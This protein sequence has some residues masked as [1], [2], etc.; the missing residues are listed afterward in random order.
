M[1]EMFL[2]YIWQ[3]QYFNRVDLATTAGEPLHVFSAGLRN[4]DSGP[5]FQNAK[6]RLGEMQWVG[7]VEIHVKASGWAQHR[8]DDDE[9]YDN[10][11]LHVVWEDDKPTTLREMPTLELKHRVDPRLF[12]SY[13]GLINS[14]EEIPCAS[15]L[16]NIKRIT[17]YSALDRALAHR[18]ESKSQEIAGLLARN[19]GDWEETSY[20]LLGR[21]FGFK[22]NGQ[23]F[24]Q[25]AQMVP[26]KTLMKHADKLFQMEAMLFGVAGFLND[27]EEFD[28]VRLLRREYDILRRKYG[29]DH[30]QMNKAQWKFLR[31]R[32]AN[33][34]TFRIAQ[35]A[36]ILYYNK[37][38]FSMLMHS[39]EEE[40]RTAL[41]APPS[42][43]WQSHYNFK[44]TSSVREAQLGESST[45]NI[46]I[47]TVVPL[48][49]C[50]ADEKDDPAFMEK[51][52]RIL[53]AL[54]SE[55]NA[56][57]R[58]WSEVSVRSRNAFDSQAL[59]ELYNNFC[60]RHRCLDCN[61]GASLIKPQ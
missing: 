15:R 4:T 1:S 44:N 20:Q 18:M 55:T 19:L 51:A 41:N 46:L 14:A 56:I 26:Y 61:I 23:P 49:I 30:V 22:V 37:N 60:S 8:H 5:D 13:A 48:Y 12:E 6:I 11:I 42:S 29:L 10:V 54:P 32:P 21:N 47:N 24:F 31:L 3:Y 7:T 40:L 59:L 35:F 36:A 57:I 39:D 27:A 33:F 28:Y 58:K 45:I 38:I 17:L 34:P 43:F 2:H 16:Q 52:M 25:L 9:A 53:Y 50:Y